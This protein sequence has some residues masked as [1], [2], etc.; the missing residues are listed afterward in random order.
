AESAKVVNENGQGKQTS[1]DRVG[2]IAQVDVEVFDLQGPVAAHT[3]RWPERGLHATANHPAGLPGLEARDRRPTRQAPYLPAWLNRGGGKNV[4]ARGRGKG[5]LGSDFRPGNTA[6]HVPKIALMR[7]AEA[8]TPRGKPVDCLL[9][10]PA[11]GSC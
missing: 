8:R 6:G 3:E 5:V 7:P 2:D 1:S 10:G 11:L 4:E 9:A